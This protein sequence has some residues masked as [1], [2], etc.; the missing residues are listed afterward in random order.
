VNTKIE[1]FCRAV[2]D[3]PADT[4]QAGSVK[5]IE[6]RVPVYI[7]GKNVQFYFKGGMFM[8]EK[9]FVRSLLQLLT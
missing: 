4:K 7:S 8:V 2:K 1:I 5:V 9:E 6:E 3:F